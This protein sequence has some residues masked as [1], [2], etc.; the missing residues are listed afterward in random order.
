MENK[1]VVY[2]C[3]RAERKAVIHKASCGQTGKGNDVSL[4]IEDNWLM[5]M[6]EPN[7]RWF[8]FFDTLNEAMAFGAL[9]PNRQLRLCGQ[10]LKDQK[11]NL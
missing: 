4:K 7:D 1:F 11:N 3:W 8:G 6:N 10:C 9:L 5:N 2:E